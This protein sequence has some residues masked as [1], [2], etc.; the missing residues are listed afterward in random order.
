[1]LKSDGE[2]EETVQEVMDMY[3]MKESKLDLL[4]EHCS[5]VLG[6]SKFYTAGPT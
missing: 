1:M 6:L 5:N 3:G 2:K 4:L